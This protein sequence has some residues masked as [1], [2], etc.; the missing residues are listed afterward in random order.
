MNELKFINFGSDT[1]WSP[2]TVA[3]ICKKVLDYAKANNLAD[4]MLCSVEDNTCDD[5]ANQRYDVEICFTKNG[6]LI[7]QKL[8][9]LK[10]EVI[11]GNEFH[12]RIN[13]FYPKQ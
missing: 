4:V 12:K 2:D 1:G 13:E 11:D 8:L 7:R 5:K 10:G 3:K 6:Q 9:I